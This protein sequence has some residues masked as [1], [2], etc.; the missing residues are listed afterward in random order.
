MLEFTCS[1]VILVLLY[2]VVITIG[3][4]IGDLAAVHKATRDGAREA[5]ITGSI[6]AGEIKAVQTA[7]VWG[8]SVKKQMPHFW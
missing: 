7:W 5:A 2:L 3:L 6:T 1:I 4:R 8:L